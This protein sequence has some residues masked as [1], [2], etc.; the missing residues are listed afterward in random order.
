V[1]IAHGLLRSYACRVTC[2]ATWGAF[3]LLTGLLLNTASAHAE[4]RVA[5]VIGNDSYVNLGADRQLRK[6]ANDA[7]AVGDALAKIGFTVIRGANLGRQGMIDKLAELTSQ[8]ESGDTAAFFYAGHGVAIGGVNYLVPSDVPAVTPEAEARVRGASIAEADV[9]AE[10]EARGVRVALLV[11]DACRD[12]P[13][14][15]TATRSIGNTRGLV[16]ARSARGVFTI[17]SAGIGQTALDRLEPNDPDRDSVFTRVFVDELTKPGIDLAGLAI[18]VRERV[19][20]LALQAKDDFGRPEPHDQTPAYYDQTVGGRIYL[21]GVSAAVAPPVAPP[22]VPPASG[23]VIANASPTA[24]ASVTPGPQAPNEPLPPDVPIDSN[25]LHLVETHPFFANAPPVRVSAFSVDSSTDTT[26]SGGGGTSSSVADRNLFVRWLRNG[27]VRTD[28][29]TQTTSTNNAGTVESSG[30]NVFVFAANGL[31][32]LGSRYTSH[33]RL[34]TSKGSSKAVSIGNLSGSIFPMR[35]GNRFS[36]QITTQESGT[37]V[38]GSRFAYQTTMSYQCRVVR[39]L[40]AN[41][42]HSSL[43]GLAYLVECDDQMTIVQ[44]AQSVSSKSQMRTVFFD[45]LGYWITADP[46]APREQLTEGVTTITVGKYVSTMTG[47][48]ILKSVSTVP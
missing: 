35:I 12:N 8:L 20:Q 40:D 28:D 47:M 34:G 48:N 37:A 18:E 29:S 7:Q 22:A 1:A 45:D 38:G 41:R 14:P 43:T 26:T 5:L 3:A 36:Y 39:T 46:V 19:A 31:I 4:K 33:S 30:Q 24:P 32:T 10:L 2:R 25:V 11:L 21:A 6:A 9:V 16:D 27:I 13:F 44:Q 42:F 15:R 23:P 17:Y